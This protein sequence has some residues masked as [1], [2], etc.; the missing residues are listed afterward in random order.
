MDKLIKFIEKAKL[1]HGDKYN[2]S[3]VEFVNNKTKVKIICPIHGEF[4][5]FV[6]S[7]I[8][9]K[10]CNLCGKLSSSIKLKDTFED[11]HWDDEKSSLGETTN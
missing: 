3:L 2:Y 8:R 6:Y 9:G 11:L 10:G 7:H 5:Q 4:E 1:I